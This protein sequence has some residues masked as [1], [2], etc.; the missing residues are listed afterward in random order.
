MNLFLD[1]ELTSI[2]KGEEVFLYKKLGAQFREV[3]GCHGVVFSVWAP[4][5]KKVSV[6][7]DFNG[8]DSNANPLSIQGDS[9]I[10]ACF[11]PGI[12]QISFQDLS[13]FVP[14]Y[15]KK[16]FLDLL[17]IRSRISLISFRISY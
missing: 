8:W 6:I 15:P 16:S 14:G 4:N 3:E 10:W 7:G 11:V 2:Q 17:T 1:S 12:S 13:K 5:A 9:G